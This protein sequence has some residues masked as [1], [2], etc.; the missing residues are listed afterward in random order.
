MPVSIPSKTKPNDEQFDDLFEDE[1]MDQQQLLEDIKIDDNHI[2]QQLESY[3][4]RLNLM[5]Q[6]VP[7]S[8]LFCSG[9]PGVGKSFVL[10]HEC[11]SKH[12]NY[13]GTA[14]LNAHAFNRELYKYRDTDILVIDDADGLLGSGQ[15]V[16]LVKGGFGPDR[17]VYWP[18]VQARK[19]QQHKENADPRYDPEIPPPSYKVR[20]RLVLL[21]N[22]HVANVVRH[23]KPQLKQAFEPLF[24]RG[25]L[26]IHIDPSDDDMFDY[27]VWL[28][29]KGDLFNYRKNNNDEIVNDRISKS[30]ADEALDWFITHRLKLVELTPRLLSD[31]GS[32]AHHFELRNVPK[33]ERK[34][35]YKERFLKTKISTV[36]NGNSNQF[37]K[38]HIVKRAES[39]F[40]AGFR[41]SDE[42]KK[43]IANFA[44]INAGR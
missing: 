35:Q 7:G 39:N 25:G 18:T 8:L 30:A 21:P 22:V 41:L 40:G 27:T 33:A 37:P 10:K 26:P 16:N 11:K 13:A 12:I 14:P 1:K 36:V 17:T 28:A 43:I 23:K 9:A 4:R 19:N 6:R 31:L 38:H 42:T 3:K 32:L 2:Y 44:R 29:T 5:F 20:T 24:S 15:M 34:I